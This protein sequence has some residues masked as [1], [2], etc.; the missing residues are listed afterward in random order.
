MLKAEIDAITTAASATWRVRFS[1]LG[2][3]LG[4]LPFATRQAISHNNRG[5]LLRD[6]GRLQ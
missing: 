1:D 4:S 6:T 2:K 5:I 3:F